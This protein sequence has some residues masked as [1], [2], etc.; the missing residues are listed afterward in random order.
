MGEVFGFEG[1]TYQKLKEEVWESLRVR[2]EL[3]L[4]LD[5]KVAQLLQEVA[6]IELFEEPSTYRLKPRGITMY[7]DAEKLASKI[8]EIIVDSSEKQGLSAGVAERFEDAP[9]RVKE[10]IRGVARFIQANFYQKPEERPDIAEVK[11]EVNKDV[12]R[13]H[14]N[15]RESFRKE[16]EIAMDQLEI[17]FGRKAPV[18]T[19]VPRVEGAPDA[20]VLS[21]DGQEPKS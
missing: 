2:D 12:V 9:S 11:L 18:P 16:F 20:P 8:H 3:I 19:V 21:E 7:N 10:T 4:F 5:D 17:K 1:T 14:P 15:W 6:V 13:D